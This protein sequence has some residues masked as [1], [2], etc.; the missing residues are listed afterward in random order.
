MSGFKSAEEQKAMGFEPLPNSGSG[1]SGGTAS[2]QQTGFRDEK[3]GV[4][5]GGFQDPNA[6]SGFSQGGFQETGQ[7]LRGEKQS[8]PQ[9][10]GDPSFNP[11]RTT[12]PG[13]TQQG[14]FS[15]GG[16]QDTS[17]QSGYSQGGFQDTGAQSGFSQGGFQDT[18]AKSGS[19]QHG[20]QEPGKDLR[21]EKP[22]LPQDIGDP[23]F[24]PQRSTDPGL[25][26][27][28]ASGDNSYSQ[29]GFQDTSS[30]AQ[31]PGSN[32]SQG[33]FQETGDKSYSQTGFQDTSSG[34][35]SFSKGG[36]PEP[37][38]KS[39][40]EGYKNPTDSTYHQSGFQETSGT[41]RDQQIPTQHG[42]QPPSD[43]DENTKDY[44]QHGD[45][46]ATEAEK[47]F[48]Q[49]GFNPGGSNLPGQDE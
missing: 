8:L 12:D 39:Q 38:S 26:K 28:G 6:Q 31:Q 10:L 32:L 47:E 35:Q 40:Q 45:Q 3:D 46:P 20:Y 2:F 24:T 15:Q 30:G 18:N 29:T 13:L 19:Q 37:G 33:G 14:G 21:G 43:R 9:D 44:L 23:S 17:A 22:T 5:Q 34:G 25:S 49:S 41:G 16:F 7:D 1:T 36:L 11:Q 48:A 42:F 4:Q 27:I